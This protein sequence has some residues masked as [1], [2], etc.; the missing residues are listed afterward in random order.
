MTAAG[1]KFEDVI[2]LMRP[3]PALSVSLQQHC[4]AM[5]MDR[6]YSWTYNQ[7]MFA[8]SKARKNLR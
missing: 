6:S 3:Q 2:G 4:S 5:R 1:A 8:N 7:L